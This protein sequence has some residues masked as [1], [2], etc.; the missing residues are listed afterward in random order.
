V[1]IRYSIGKD[2]PTGS[3]KQ[4]PECHRRMFCARCHVK[5]RQHQRRAQ[6]HPDTGADRIKCLRQIQPAGRVA[7]RP[8]GD[9]ERIC[10]RLQNRQTGGKMNRASRKKP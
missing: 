6:Q 5:I 9:D 7:L 3:R 8:D 2:L 10:R 1:N 4:F